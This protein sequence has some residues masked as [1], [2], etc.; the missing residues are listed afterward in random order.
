MAHL[1]TRIVRSRGRVALQREADGAILDFVAEGADNPSLGRKMRN[2]TLDALDVYLHRKQITGHQYDAG[3]W[4]RRLHLT[5]YGSGVA[6][7][8][9]DGGGGGSPDRNWT[10]SSRASYALLTIT[11]LWRKMPRDQAFVVERVVYYDE[12][13]GAAAVRLGKPSRHGIG[14]LRDGLDAVRAIKD[15][16]S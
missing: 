5:A 3:D 9:F 15:G 4:V 7:V 11:G 14:I 12:W 6:T 1:P 8:R 10:F 2:R 16:Q 13:A